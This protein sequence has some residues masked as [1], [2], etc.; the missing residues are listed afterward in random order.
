MMSRAP[1][2]VVFDVFGTLAQIGERRRPYRQLQQLMSRYGRA[3][4]A[5][6]A[7]RM[8]SIETGLAGLTREFQVDLPACELADIE[9]NLHYELATIRLYDDALPTLALLRSAGLKLALC[10]NL[11]APYSIPIR[12][13]LPPLDVYA[14]SFRVGAVKPSA[15]IYQAVCDDLRC[16]PSDV[17]FVG[18]TVEADVEGPRS[19]GMQACLLKRD[20][21]AP[22]LDVVP[23]L[24]DLF[25]RLGLST[26][27][28]DV[29]A[30][31]T[32]AA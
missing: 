13:L 10:S 3:P 32:P 30:M 31:E 11:A 7:V 19:F 25:S 14:W 23:R 29:S 8:M 20:A 24:T 2:A 21:A 27:P 17:L 22:S 1:Q 9:M 16:P 12:L 4:A 18:D 26:R 6:D 5:D 15:R 28:N